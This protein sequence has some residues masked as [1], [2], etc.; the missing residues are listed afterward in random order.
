L[1]HLRLLDNLADESF[2]DSFIRCFILPITVRLQD[3]ALA[4]LE[5]FLT[6][7]YVFETAGQFQMR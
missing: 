5:T 2:S 3:D 7:P 1:R 4:R 6:E